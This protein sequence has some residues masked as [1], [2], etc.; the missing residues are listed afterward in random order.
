M[1]AYWAALKKCSFYTFKCLTKLYQQKMLDLIQQRLT[2]ALE[3]SDQV[4][5]SIMSSSRQVF[6]RAHV[7]TQTPGH[8]ILHEHTCTHT[9]IWSWTGTTCPF[10]AAVRPC[11][12]GKIER[13]KIKEL[14]E[15]KPSFWDLVWVS[16]WPRMWEPSAQFTKFRLSTE[17]TALPMDVNRGCSQQTMMTGS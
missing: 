17:S 8:T 10:E 9:C 16:C 11:L 7:H 6:R 3:F 4:L 14:W 15:R 2:L 5:K 13:W 1:S 12:W